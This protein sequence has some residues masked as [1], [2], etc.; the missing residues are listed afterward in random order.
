[1]IRAASATA[2][3]SFDSNPSSSAASSEI[4]RS[5]PRSRISRPFAEAAT[6]TARPSS[7]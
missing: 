3:S 5:R 2:S 7:A 6:T 4:R 1:M